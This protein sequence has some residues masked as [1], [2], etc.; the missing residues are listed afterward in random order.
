V[1]RQ[2]HHLAAV[3]G[4]LAIGRERLKTRRQDPGPPPPAGARRIAVARRVAAGVPNREGG[5]HRTGLQTRHLKQPRIR[6]ILVGSVLI[7]V[8]D[9]LA[10]GPA[11]EAERL[12][13]RR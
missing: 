4:G 3:K 1:G 6:W 12:V 9:M 8:E 5:D 10:V 2:T 7:S 13:V 11:D